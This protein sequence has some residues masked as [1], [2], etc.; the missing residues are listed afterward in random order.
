[1]VLKHPSMTWTSQ[2][3]AQKLT[4]AFSQ[5]KPPLLPASTESPSADTFPSS[6]L[7]TNAVN[8]IVSIKQENSQKYCVS[9]NVC[10][11]ILRTNCYFILAIRD[12]LYDF[13]RGILKN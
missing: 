2:A 9:F 1:M 7:S 8:S 4:K 5:G 11:K 3:T 10:K 12:L 13:S 6:S